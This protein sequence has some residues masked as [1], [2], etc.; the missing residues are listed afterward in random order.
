MRTFSGDVETGHTQ[1]L[2]DSAKALQIANSRL[3]DRYCRSE[4]TTG[5]TYCD[6]HVV[7]GDPSQ[8]DGWWL[9]DDVADPG[10]NIELLRP[11]AW[12]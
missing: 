6:G 3:L 2:L 11:V 1:Y 4:S 9:T 7:R 12:T 5:Q 8:F 10:T